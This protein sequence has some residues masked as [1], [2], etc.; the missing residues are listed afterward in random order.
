M[1]DNTPE[2][3]LQ[4]QIQLSF[5]CW[6][7]IILKCFPLLWD[8][9]LK[10]QMGIQAGS[11]F[12]QRV[13]PYS[14]SLCGAAVGL[15]DSCLPVPLLHGGISFNW[16]ETRTS[17]FTR[18]SSM[19]LSF[20]RYEEREWTC[21]ILAPTFCSELSPVIFPYTG[22]RGTDKR[23]LS[24]SKITVP[25]AAQMVKTRVSINGRMDKDVIC[26]ILFSH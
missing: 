9:T 13:T 26:G 3:E 10:T 22:S 24:T 16:K 15:P 2:G 19:V 1:N 18:C 25:N 4:S 6:E 5:L 12:S 14:G 21:C 7:E 8:V 11:W 17:E 20:L 23:K